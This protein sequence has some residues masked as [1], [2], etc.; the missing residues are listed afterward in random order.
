MRL[1]KFAKQIYDKVAQKTQQLS[2][3]FSFG[4]T[5]FSKEILV[6]HAG[7]EPATSPLSGVRSKPTELRARRPKEKTEKWASS[8]GIDVSLLKNEKF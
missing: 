8:P 2:Q 5:S 4:K 6:G 7:F 1:Y 3:G